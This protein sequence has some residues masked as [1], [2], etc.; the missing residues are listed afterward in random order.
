MSRSSALWLV[1][2]LVA[3]WAS[4][5]AQYGIADCPEGCPARCPDQLTSQSTNVRQHFSLEK[6]W[7][8]YYELQYHDNT[9]PRFMSCQ[10]SVKSPNADQKTYKDLFSL[11]VAGNT[12]AVC[13]LEFNLTTH[14][15][16]FLGH[17]RGSFRPDLTNINNTVID[18]GRSKNGSFFEW[19]LEFQC[20]D[21]FT[22][23]A[24]AGTPSGVIFAAINF[25]HRL[26]LVPAG[27]LELMEERARARGVGWLLDVAPGLTRVNQKTCVQHHTYPRHNASTRMCGQR[28]G[29][30]LY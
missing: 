11:H 30:S 12:T 29:L 17:W 9:Q 20:A 26:P 25:Y 7:G 23:A 16:V 22:E 10:R 24:K 4:W 14:P 21:N 15:G 2:A 27:T 19:T 1:S 6:F 5:T 8:T 3:V 28:L 18:V 13:D